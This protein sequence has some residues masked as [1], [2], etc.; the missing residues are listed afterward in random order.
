MLKGYRGHVM[1]PK[2]GAGKCMSVH[3]RIS[4]ETNLPPA[5]LTIDAAAK[6]LSLSRSTVYALIRDGIIKT[7]KL[8]SDAPRIRKADL[9]S[10]I[11]ES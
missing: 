9:D 11:Q 2:S 3:E 4:M 8:T 1:N 5:L 6:Y 7:V 10:M